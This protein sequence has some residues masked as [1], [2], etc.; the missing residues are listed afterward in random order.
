MT[1]DVSRVVARSEILP[2]DAGES[3]YLWS[4]SIS[5]PESGE[6]YRVDILHSLVCGQWSGHQ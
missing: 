6:C 1:T 4:E 3:E 5:G 2:T